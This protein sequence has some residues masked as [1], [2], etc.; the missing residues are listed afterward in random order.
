VIQTLVYGSMISGM[1][2]MTAHLPNLVLVGLFETELAL[3]LSYYRLVQAAVAL[4]GHVHRHAVVGA[5]LLQDPWR[6]PPA[7][8]LR[9]CRSSTPRSR[10]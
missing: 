8:A 3:S 2:I 5:A 9:R 7:A 1:C 4:P 10:K 6:G